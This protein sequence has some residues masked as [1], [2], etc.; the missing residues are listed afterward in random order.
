MKGKRR[1]AR[2]VSPESAVNKEP[3]DSRIYCMVR[4]HWERELLRESPLP[5]DIDWENLPPVFVPYSACSNDSSQRNN[6]KM[7]T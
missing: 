5:P 6:S 1:E 7:Q 4:S 3:T 2:N